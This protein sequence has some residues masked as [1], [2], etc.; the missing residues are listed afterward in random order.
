MFQVLNP[1]LVYL[2]VVSMS[3]DNQS[4]GRLATDAQ[5]ENH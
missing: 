2:K 1:T 3:L 5:W 4:Q